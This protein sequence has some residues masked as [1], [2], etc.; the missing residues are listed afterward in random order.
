MPITKAVQ[1]DTPPGLVD[2]DSQSELITSAE[3]AAQW[4]VLDVPISDE[5]LCAA[6][7]AIDSSIGIDNTKLSRSELKVR[8]RHLIANGYNQEQ[9]KSTAG[10]HWDKIDDIH[11]GDTLIRLCGDHWLMAGS[12][13]R[14]Y[15]TD[16]SKLHVTSVGDRGYVQGKCFKKHEHG[17][18]AVAEY[19]FE[20][21][22]G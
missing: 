22:K 14:P 13:G 4:S 7:G 19:F 17:R 16:S 1:T 11:P 5:P 2:T 8:A 15:F 12:N 9:I 10:S 18:V 6:A 3:A 20:I 21:D